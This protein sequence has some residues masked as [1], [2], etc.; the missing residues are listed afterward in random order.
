MPEPSVSVS[1]TLSYWDYYQS[2]VILVF[3]VFRTVRTLLIVGA[4]M[5]GL[6]AFAT[7]RPTPG[8]DWYQIATDS[9]SLLWVGER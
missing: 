2:S 8:E 5:A 9:K 4:L 3:R 1:V 7:V 6:F